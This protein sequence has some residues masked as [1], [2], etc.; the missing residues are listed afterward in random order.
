MTKK[1]IITD[2]ST[3]IGILKPYLKELKVKNDYLDLAEGF[4]DLHVED[5]RQGL[6]WLRAILKTAY[7]TFANAKRLLTDEQWKQYELFGMEDF[8]EHQEVKILR[9]AQVGLRKAIVNQDRPNLFKKGYI[10]KQLSA[11]THS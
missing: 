10:E 6:Y 4:E 7:I 8:E 1:Q 2:L 3:G 11:K 5:L 9:A